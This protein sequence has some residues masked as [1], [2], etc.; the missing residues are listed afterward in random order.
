MGGSTFS[1]RLQRPLA[2][3][4]HWHAAWTKVPGDQGAGHGEIV[5][6]VG[7]YRLLRCRNRT[8]SP[9]TAA[10]ATLVVGVLGAQFE[11]SE[12]SE[13][14]IAIGSTATAKAARRCWWTLGGCSRQVRPRRR[15]VWVAS[16]ESPPTLGR[17]AFGGGRLILPSRSLC[18]CDGVTLA[19]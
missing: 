11:D 5:A 7:A 17:F 4:W 10:T 16:V 2:M 15:R 19:G 13:N 1:M 14:Q 3:R 18:G 6:I 8:A 12:V 9:E